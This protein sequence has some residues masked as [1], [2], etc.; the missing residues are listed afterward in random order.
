MHETVRAKSAR[1][2]H[3]TIICTLSV[4]G[5]ASLPEWRGKQG[6]LRLDGASTLV[7]GRSWTTRQ[8]RA[9][10][11]KVRV[12]GDNPDVPRASSADWSV[13]RCRKIGQG[14]V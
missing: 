14:R 10:T 13:S 4:S 7:S 11:Q 3:D 5:R 2:A 1:G 12:G 6:R 9:G 8:T